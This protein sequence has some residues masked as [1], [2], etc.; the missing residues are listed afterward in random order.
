MESATPLLDLAFVLLMRTQRHVT[1]VYSQSIQTTLPASRTETSSECTCEKP[2]TVG[3]EKSDGI[4][5]NLKNSQA[6]CVAVDVNEIKLLGVVCEEM[7][8]THCFL[9]SQ[10]LT[11]Y[12]S[13]NDTSLAGFFSEGN[14]CCDQ[15]F[16][17]C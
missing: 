11:M 7:L 3:L 1:V 15:I 10:R 14:F 6:D 4:P 12:D 13:A 8:T 16:I 9:I 2:L 17:N 5:A